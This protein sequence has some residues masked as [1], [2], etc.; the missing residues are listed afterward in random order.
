MINNNT[1]TTPPPSAAES[2][3]KTH[4]KINS[5]EDY[6]NEFGIN[7]PAEKKY[8]TEERQMRLEKRKSLSALGEVFKLIAETGG[9]LAGSYTDKRDPNPYMAK[10]DAKIQ[11]LKDKD[12]LDQRRIEQ[13][14]VNNKVRGIGM[15][16]D[17]ITRKD[18]Q[19]YNSGEKQLD[20]ENTS[21]LQDER[22]AHDTQENKDQRSFTRERDKN[23]Y[24]QDDKRIA[25]RQSEGQKDRES[26]ERIAK[27]DRD[28]NVELRKQ[29][30]TVGD[31]SDQEI[32]DAAAI[33]SEL[34]KVEFGSDV[35]I[36]GYVKE[37]IAGKT[38]PSA[39]QIRMIISQYPDL[40]PQEKDWTSVTTP[41]RVEY[42][43]PI[44]SDPNNSDTQTDENLD[45]FGNP[46]K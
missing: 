34:S 21:R 19:N 42:E 4:R 9:A 16:N 32:A 22:L 45:P 20:R 18:N 10:L 39:E 12:L 28:A 1:S 25:A 26:R 44:L 46:V 31:L 24:E 30:A 6:L 36:P 15:Y 40:I 13:N 3:E 33:I 8:S 27:A 41:E 2:K 11:E 14:R 37:I 17:Y 5:V 43:P 29:L 35:N 7:L 38:K 23:K